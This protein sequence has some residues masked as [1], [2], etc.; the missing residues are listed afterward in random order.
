MRNKTYLLLSFVLVHWGC[1]ETPSILIDK[2][3]KEVATFPIGLAV[4]ANYLTNLRYS[5][6]VLEEFNSLTAEREMKQNVLMPEPNTYNW[7]Y[8]DSIIAFAERHQMRVHGHT[9]LWHSS[10]PYWLDLFQGTDAEFETLIKT[11]IQTV[12][13]RY[14]GKITSWD[15]VNE[16]FE[17][18]GGEL[19]NSLFQRRIGDDYVAKCFQWAREADPDV[20]LFYNDYG[21]V[22]NK[23]KC[24]AVI[25]ML[26]DFENNNIPI[27]GIG[28]QMHIS[29]NYPRNS[30]IEKAVDLFVERG[31]KIHFSELDVRVNPNGTATELTQ[32]LAEQQFRKVKAI[33]EIYNTIPTA[34]KSGITLWGLRDNESWVLA[35]WGNLDWALFFDEK[36]ERKL[37]HQGFLQAF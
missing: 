32:K 4:Q 31:L 36:Y 7:I 34:Q 10:I 15:V 25:K 8:A 2:N 26:D 14:A 24:E 3:L 16:A 23:S 29:D 19:R 35:H 27:D 1:Q 20:L 5:K 21:L 11:Y 22:W 6:T 12:V 37:A 28:L 17:D 9:L 18:E 13:S 30:D 33:T